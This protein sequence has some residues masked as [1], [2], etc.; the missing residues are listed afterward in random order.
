MRSTFSKF[1]PARPSQSRG[2]VCGSD[3][4]EEPAEPRFAKRAETVA[5]HLRREIPG[6]VVSV[7]RDRPFVFT[8][9]TTGTITSKVQL[10]FGDLVAEISDAQVGF[11]FRRQG[12]CRHFTQE[13]YRSLEVIGFMKI[14]LY[15]VDHGRVT[16]AALGFR[17]TRGAWNTHKNGFRASFRQHRHKIP[18]AISQ[19][20]DDLISAEEVSVFPFIA[21]LEID[22]ELHSK[23]TASNIFSGIPGWHGEF[24]VGNRRDKQYLFG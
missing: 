15:A 16:W 23:E 13:L 14:K 22:G 6:V 3:T 8:I 7:S 21:N 4:Q 12:R 20:I 5:A 2:D 24:D 9:R 19:T 18:M 10:L 11:W 17:P 1:F